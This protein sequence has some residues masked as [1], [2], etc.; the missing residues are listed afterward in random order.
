MMELGVAPCSLLLGASLQ[1]PHSCDGRIALI[2]YM[3]LLAR[4]HA[5][6]S[7]FGVSL[8]LIRMREAMAMLRYVSCALQIKIFVCL[9]C[10]GRLGGA[11]ER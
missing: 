10:R 5:T 3:P 9:C 11:C 7:K 4:M 2:L 8:F 6:M 1:S